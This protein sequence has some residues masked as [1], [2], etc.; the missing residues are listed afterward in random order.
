MRNKPCTTWVDAI[1]SD[2][3]K[4]ELENELPLPFQT[5]CPECSE[6]AES[7]MVDGYAMIINCVVCGYHETK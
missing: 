7:I 1:H 3:E 2:Y 4:K 6:L 5:R